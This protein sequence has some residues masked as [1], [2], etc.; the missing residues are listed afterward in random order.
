MSQ[1]KTILYTGT[2]GFIN[3]YLLRRTHY[4]GHLTEKYKF[5]GIDK[6][7]NPHA[8]KSIYINK[9]Y[10]FHLGDIN[11][12]YIVDKIFQIHRPDIIIHGAAQ[13]FVDKSNQD[14]EIFM[15]TNVVGTQVLVDAALRYGVEK[16]V[17]QSTD[18]VNSHS[19]AE[20]APS[21]ESDA[22]NPRNSYSSSK[23]ASELLVQA[24][25][26]VHGLNY[27]ITRSANVFGPR[28]PKRNLI[29]VAMARLLS[30]Q[31]IPLYG[32]G[33]QIRSWIHVDDF[34]TAFW[35]IVEQGQLNQVYNIST[36]HY[37]T[38]LDLAQLICRLMGQPQTQIEFITDRPGHDF[39]YKSDFSKLQQLGW[40]PQDK[41]FS[42]QLAEVCH[43]YAQNQW[44]LQEEKDKK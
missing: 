7:L 6:L 4:E 35:T 25:H 23:Y 18:E 29:P 3:G 42:T 21:K 5:V 36:G 43:W 19:Q 40:V 31:K 2:C 14:P 16:F 41:D 44:Y 39:C 30:G 12:S 26:N 8:N 11:D 17:L 15:K 22:P 9:D 10:T 20:V 13:T 33:S 32:D 24:A 1:R 34:Y 27:Q 28:Q 37:S 38:N